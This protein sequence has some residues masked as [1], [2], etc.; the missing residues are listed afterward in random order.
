MVDK[1]WCAPEHVGGT[2]SK[3]ITYR[4]IMPYHIPEYRTTYPLIED[5]RLVELEA[6]ADR[7][8]EIKDTGTIES[9]REFLP[10]EDIRGDVGIDQV[11]PLHAIKKVFYVNGV[12]V[13]YLNEEYFDR[14]GN[15]QRVR[16]EQLSANSS[17]P[18]MYCK[19]NKKGIMMKTRDPVIHG[20]GG[21][22]GWRV[23]KE[24]NNP[25]SVW[26][27]KEEQ[28]LAKKK[29]PNTKQKQ[30]GGRLSSIGHL[31]D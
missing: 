6:E 27:W 4:D 20:Y 14:V 9:L 17:L 19:R 3:R 22:T 10:L 7:I 1:Q 11:L 30:G 13:N 12:V 26:Y 18:L 2:A 8:F 31:L 28:K 23:F 29:K 24:D 15:T 16:L 5:N 25:D 21:L